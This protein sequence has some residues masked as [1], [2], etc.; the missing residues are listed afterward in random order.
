[1]TRIVLHPSALPRYPMSPVLMHEDW[2]WW[3][4]RIFGDVTRRY[5]PAPENI[6]EAILEFNTEI[7]PDTEIT[8]PPV[9]RVITRT[10][11]SY[12]NPIRSM[13]D[14]RSTEIFVV[15]YGSPGDRWTMLPGNTCQPGDYQITELTNDRFSPGV[16]NLNPNDDPWQS[17]FSAGM[18]ELVWPPQ[19]AVQR[20]PLTVDEAEQLLSDVYD[21]QLDDTVLAF[22]RADQEERRRMA[23]AWD[24]PTEMITPARPE[25][26]TPELDLDRPPISNP[27]EPPP[28]QDIS[29]ITSGALPVGLFQQTESSSVY[30]LSAIY[31]LRGGFTRPIV[32]LP[33]TARVT[34]NDDGTRTYLFDAVNGT[35][36]GVVFSDG[37]EVEFSTVTMT[38]PGQVSVTISTPTG[39]SIPTGQPWLRPANWGNSNRQPGVEVVSWGDI[40]SGGYARQSTTWGE[41]RYRPP[42]PAGN[43]LPESEVIDEIDRLVNEQ[44]APG[45]VDNYEVNRYPSCENC[46][47][48]WHGLDCEDEDCECINTNWLKGQPSSSS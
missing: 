36:D 7:D 1:M 5:T 39:M 3:T 8:D 17:R 20:R 37:T 14:A 15:H 46:E 10:Q 9:M 21:G 32:P 40:V 16:M 30:S 26:T 34:E 27:S 19:R 35:Y 29:R 2:H 31:A 38:A 22:Q 12:G 6:R 28:S 33:Q 47:H 41:T 24:I 42:N 43:V 4:C 44:V 25:F 48:D 13:M 45:P 11:I 23:A 18:R